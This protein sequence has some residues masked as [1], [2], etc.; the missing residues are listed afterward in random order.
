MPPPQAELL[1]LSPTCSNCTA[2]L[3]PCLIHLARPQPL[4]EHP[5]YI[6]CTLLLT[7]IQIKLIIN[8]LAS[9]ALSV[10]GTN[11][12]T[13]MEEYGKCQVG[14]DRLMVVERIL[15]EAELSL[16]GRQGELALAWRTEK[17]G[18]T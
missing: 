10:S 8:P 15:G 13:A 12:K 3:L 5:P 9:R 4:L 7:E 1:H 11:P 6:P 16:R 14:R 17:A 18:R 2:F